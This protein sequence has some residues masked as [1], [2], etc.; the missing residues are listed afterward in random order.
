[1]EQVKTIIE[2]G[3]GTRILN[4]KE[5]VRYKD[6]LYFFVLRDVTVL[7]KQT[8]LGVAWAVINPFFS[9]LVFTIIFG[10]LANIP[11]DGIP[12][13][14]FSYCALMPWTYFSSSSN[15]STNSLIGAR[16]IFTKVYF[17]RIIFPLTPIFSK[18]LDF[19]ISFLLL[20]ILLLYYG[21]T[22]SAQ[23]IFLPLLIVIMVAS[24]ASI[25]IWLSS[26]ALQYRDVRFAMTLLMQLLMYAAPVVFPASLILEKFGPTAYLFYGLYPMT[27]VIEGFRS[28]IIGHTAMPWQLIGMSALSA[29]VLLYTGLRYFNSVERKFADVS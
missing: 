8:I 25:G 10:T 11:S 16:N 17:P 13:T 4:V 14:I 24:S 2:A 9:T 7:Y 6:L 29:T 12:Y 3:K 18:L 21:I 1:M 27:G 23:I 22:P 19:F 5:L 26:L 28:A 20:G 15:A